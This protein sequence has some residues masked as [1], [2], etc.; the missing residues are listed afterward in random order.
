MDVQPLEKNNQGIDYAKSMNDK[1]LKYVNVGLWIFNF[2]LV[3]VVVIITGFSAFNKSTMSGSLIYQLLVLLPLLLIAGLSLFQW[4]RQ[5]ISGKTF[6]LT[7]LVLLSVDLLTIWLIN[8]QSLDWSNFL[9]QW[10]L[11]YQN[12]S[13]QESFRQITNI[14]DYTPLYSY[15]L[16]II[17]HIFSINNCLYA[18][19]YLS[20]IFS[21]ILAVAMELV[22][23]TA[24]KNK[25]SY[26]HLVIFL[27]L[28]PILLEFSA[29]GQCDAVYVA[30]ALFA[31]YFALKR[32]SVFCFICL[33]L[34]FALKL[35]FIFITPMILV[36][37]II[38]DQN[39]KRY[40]NWAWVWL[41]PLMYVVN[42]LPLFF[43]ANLE[44]LISVYFKQMGA[45]IEAANNCFSLEFILKQLL[46]I[47]GSTIKRILNL[48][49]AIIGIGLT[50]KLLLEVLKSHRHSSLTIRDIVYYALCFAM[51]MVYFMPKMHERFFF[52]AFVLSIVF[53]LVQPKLWNGF[54]SAIITTSLTIAY[55]IYLFFCRFDFSSHV[56]FPPLVLFMCNLGFILNTIAVIGLLLPIFVKKKNHA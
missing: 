28:P 38:R 35:Q 5:Q 29:W 43:G 30:L 15:F 12:L 33:G 18:I 54:L 27:L 55:F 2:I 11:N 56:I 50:V 20:F 3:L 48:L 53:W 9:S 25:F 4:R 34:S 52:V 39:G 10:C 19:K 23:C 32:C 6:L 17:A 26:L 7:C 46:V 36:L 22:I 1:L 8:Y 21:I 44:N 40:L 47:P 45:E 13:W 51:V 49:I 24:T 37:L 31:F 14:S 16:I 42:L 41:A